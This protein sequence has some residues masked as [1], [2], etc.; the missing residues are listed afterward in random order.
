MGYEGAKEADL[1]ERYARIATTLDAPS[2]QAQP[3]EP[4]V[5]LERALRGDPKDSAPTRFLGFYSE[6]GIHRALSAYGLAAAVAARGFPRL[7]VR[8]EAPHPFHQVLRI[9]G[10]PEDDDHLLAE[11]VAR[12]GAFVPRAPGWDA[13]GAVFAM[14]LL[15]WVALRNPNGRFTSSRPRLPGQRH[16]GLGVGAEVLELFAQASRRL[17]KDGLLEFPDH[18]H[19]AVLYGR[20]F[21][22]FSPRLEGRVRAIGRDV[23]EA[24]LARLSWAIDWDCLVDQ[25]TGETVPWAALRGEQV[26]PTSPRLA[27]WFE[28]PDYGVE[29]ARAFHDATWGID[30]VKFDRVRAERDDAP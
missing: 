28:R 27:A 16:P 15:D 3:P 6:E 4:D 25:R 20:R 7:T 14:I 17:A 19:N 18:Y 30:W 12:E 29:A 1:A 26:L 22:Y 13:D 24:G 23:G 2:L 10:G 8:I 5:S 9:Y 21:R 11:V